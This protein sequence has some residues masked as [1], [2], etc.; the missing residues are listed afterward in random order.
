MNRMLNVKINNGEV[1]E[2]DFEGTSYEL[3][4]ELKFIA[5]NI[6]CSIIEQGGFFE[7]DIYDLLNNFS[8]DV[9]ATII[10]EN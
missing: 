2:F 3:M 9:E 6:L 7:D 5:V 10:E 4:E 8:D 1:E